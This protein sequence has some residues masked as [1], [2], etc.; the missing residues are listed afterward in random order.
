VNRLGLAVALVLVGGCTSTSRAPPPDAVL[1][2]A[3]LP[4]T[5]SNA[6]LGTNIERSILLAIEQINAAGGVGSRPLYVL[7]EDTHSDVERGLVSAQRLLNAGVQ[8]ILGPEEEALAVAL[9][10][11]LEER[12]VVQIA[13]GMAAPMAQYPTG[14]WTHGIRVALAGRDLGQATAKYLASTLGQSDVTIVVEDTIENLGFANALAGSLGDAGSTLATL[15]LS[16]GEDVSAAV[17]ALLATDAP[18]K[19]LVTSVAVGA[20]LVQAWSTSGRGGQWYFAPPFRTAPFLQNVPP[21]SVEL[22]IG[23][24]Q[25]V[26]PASGKFR[27]LFEQRWDGDS[28]STVAHYYYDATV[29]LGLAI[30][31]TW[32]DGGAPALPS[33]V[34]VQNLVHTSK[35]GNTFKPAWDEVDKALDWVRA[36]NEIDYV[37]VSGPVDLADVGRLGAGLAEFWTIRDG[38]FV[39]GDPMLVRVDQF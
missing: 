2:G 31:R 24:S 10:P 18:A 9:F 20:Q 1:I 32:L 7:F 17:A 28:P 37:G 12:D 5:G 39:G 38:N 23:I 6:A 22:M 27:Q 14:F 15:H 34:L 30:E 8:A 16:P 29:L 4:Y 13:A 19:I 33:D 36:G 21:D 3:L 26:S 11:L 25:A 35:E